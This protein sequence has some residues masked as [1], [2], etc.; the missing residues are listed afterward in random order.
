MRD[1]R[2]DP[3]VG[4]WVIISSERKSRP[5]DFKKEEEKTE[6]SSFCPFCYGNEASTPPEIMAYRDKNNTNGTDWRV[7]VVPNRFPAL[8]IEGGLEKV[9]EGIYDRMSGFG[10][11]E[12]IIETPNHDD[13]LST[14]SIK[15]LEEMFWAYRDRLIDLKKDTRIKYALIFKNYGKSAGASLA[16][17]HSQ[18]IALPI[19]PKAVVEEITGSKEHYNFKERC[20][21]C[22]IIRQELSDKSRIISENEEFLAICPYASRFPFEIWVLP[23][24]HIS[25]FE[26]SGNHTVMT[27][28]AGVFSDV[29]KRLDK[30]LN[31]PSYNFFMHNS[32]FETR[33]NEYYHWHF[34]LMPRLTHVAGFERGTGFYINSTPPEEAALFLRELE[35]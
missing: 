29:F 11:H 21:F 32:T 26:E 3:I 5:T 19:V 4:R 10:A 16:H 2:K 15:A 8:Q 17:P 6:K 24:K 23:K 22:D 30:A 27:N 28:L 35:V 9:G 20:I 13:K 7:R 18:L 14:M 33:T 1:L 31:Y 34:E 25:H 12:V